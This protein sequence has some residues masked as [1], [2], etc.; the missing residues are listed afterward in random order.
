MSDADTVSPP[1][2]EG[3][4]LVVVRSEQQLRA[5]TE[6]VAVARARVRKV[7]VTEERTITVT[8]RHEEYRLDT[9][10][11]TA[12]SP[13]PAP[14]NGSPTG[15]PT[16]GSD[17]IELV[18]HAE[19]PVVTTEVVPVERIRISTERVSGEEAVTGQVQRE[20]VELDP[21]SEAGLRRPATDTSP[22]LLPRARRRPRPDAQTHIT[23][24]L[25]EQS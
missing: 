15:P 5:G 20:V 9:E 11:I 22:P 17:T 23:L 10:P 3:D 8:L 14:T 21:P 16:G 24:Q 6:T 1:H 12:D 7:I 2:D 4:E 19:R 25:E 13:A 18:L